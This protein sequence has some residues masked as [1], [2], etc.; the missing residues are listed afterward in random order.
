MS[1]RISISCAAATAVLVAFA[2][3]G[4]GEP[5]AAP[6][7]ATN[8]SAELIE[9][10]RGKQAGDRGAVFRGEM[11][12]VP[13]AAHMLMR[14]HLSEKVGTEPWRGIWA[15]GINLPRQARP[16]VTR[17]A[18]RQRVLN[19]NRGAAYRVAI[20]F[21]WYT[22]DGKEV[23]HEM[24]DSPVCRQPGKLPNPKIRDTVKVADGPT[25]ETRRYVVRVGNT[26]SVVARGVVLRLSVDGAEVDTRR[27]GRLVPGQRRSVGFV[28][29]VCRGAVVAR[30]DPDDAI[31]EIAERDNVVT[32]PCA[33]LEPLPPA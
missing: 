7:P 13:G 16:G 10:T 30:L 14:F 3:T 25:P 17:F 20:V 18:Y 9:C 15:P 4:A 19:L 32:T 1:S 33:Q 8:G 31:A 24:A 23:A 12:Q 27:I 22:A 2:W 5:A 11:T 21:R 6:A 29:P 26:G 28:G